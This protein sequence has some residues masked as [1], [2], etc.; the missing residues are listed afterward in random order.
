MTTWQRA[1]ARAVVA[2][3]FVLPLVWMAA[4]ALHRPGVPLPTAWRLWPAEVSGE[5]FGRIFHLLPLGRYTLNSLLVAA[6]A[7]PL[8]LLTGS[9]AGFA[10]ARLPQAEQR[11]WVL[12]SLALLMIPGLA[13]WSTR[14]LV[15][16]WLGWHNTLLALIAPALL[17]AGPFFVLIFYRAFRRLPVALYE[18]ALLDGAGVWLTWRRV[19]LPLTRPTVV[20]VGLLALALYWG[21]FLSPLLYLNDTTWYTL[22]VG[23]QQLQQL[24][25]SDWPLLMAGAVWTTLIPASLFFLAQPWV[26]RPA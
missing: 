24:T 15:Y 7:V 1:A 16:K 14:F 17:G 13:L 6:L 22:P 20:G 19:A 3:V 10:L 8:T 5:N 26:Q 18:A 4:A 25:R 2:A 12:L 11:R 21:D 9:W 23:L